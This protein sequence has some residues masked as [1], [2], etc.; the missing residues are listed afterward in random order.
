M[1]V[2][3]L[4]LRLWLGIRIQIGGIAHHY[5][6]NEQK[7]KLGI[8]IRKQLL[9]LYPYLN[10]HEAS[11]YSRH[12]TAAKHQCRLE[13]LWFV[14]R[15]MIAKHILPPDIIPKA[16]NKWDN[17]PSLKCDPQIKEAITALEDANNTQPRGRTGL[18]DP[19]CLPVVYWRTKWLTSASQPVHLGWRTK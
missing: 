4:W 10:S 7:Y 18:R 3:Y 15:H 2:Y 13:N 1:F 6:D 9:R 16:E 14:F 17:K 11:T 8:Q 19:T 12:L 5:W